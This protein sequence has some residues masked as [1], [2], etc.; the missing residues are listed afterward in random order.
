[1][2]FRSRIVSKAKRLPELPKAGGSYVLNAAGTGWMKDDPT[3]EPLTEEP[4][5]AT[6]E[7][8]TD[9]GGH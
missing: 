7:K 1:V 3:P 2:F 5:D 8:P 9:S 6:L 4:T